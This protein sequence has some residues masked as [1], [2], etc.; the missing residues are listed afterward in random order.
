MI[1]VD[2]VRIE[3]EINSTLWLLRILFFP[4]LV[5]SLHIVQKCTRVMVGSCCLSLW[6]G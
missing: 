5:P 3:D 1:A 2:C 6:G 4:R